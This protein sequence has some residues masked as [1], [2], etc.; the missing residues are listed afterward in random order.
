MNSKQ[1]LSHNPVNM[2]NIQMKLKIDL[3]KPTIFK[4]KYFKKKINTLI[5]IFIPI[6]IKIQIII[7]IVVIF[8][9]HKN[10]T[11]KEMTTSQIE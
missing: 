9:E 6:S 4:M 8:M 3:S 10:K 5:I 7:K 11:N 2:N 1:L